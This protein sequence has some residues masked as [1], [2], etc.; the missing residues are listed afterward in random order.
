MTSRKDSIELDSVMLIMHSAQSQWSFEE[1]MERVMRTSRIK[2]MKISA[3]L[4]KA[5]IEEKN[6]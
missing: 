3:G 5:G 1:Y 6:C 2:L 4:G